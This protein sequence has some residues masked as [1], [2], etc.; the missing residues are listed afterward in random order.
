RS[1]RAPSSA[2]CAAITYR[3]VAE[4]DCYC[5]AAGLLDP[6]LS[7]Y[8]RTWRCHRIRAARGIRGSVRSRRVG[9]FPDCGTAAGPVPKRPSPTARPQRWPTSLYAFSI[10]SFQL[11]GFAIVVG[12]LLYRPD[13]R[14]R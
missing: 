1:Y 8:L 2:A 13:P 6:E 10:T 11:T 12:G 4:R 14:Q 9:S 3:V 5:S 7:N